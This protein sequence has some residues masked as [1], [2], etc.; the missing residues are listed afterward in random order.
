MTDL[1][2]K[3]HHFLVFTL[4]EVPKDSP[5]NSQEYLGTQ[6]LGKIKGSEDFYQGCRNEEEE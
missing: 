3:T 2:K 1:A 6:S 5:W 4:M